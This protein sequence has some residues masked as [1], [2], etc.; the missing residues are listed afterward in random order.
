MALPWSKIESCKLVLHA[1]TA[2][3]KLQLF[4]FEQRERDYQ[5]YQDVPT[6]KYR[7]MCRAGETRVR[8][9]SN[10]SVMSADNM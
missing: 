8:R 6:S 1:H 5:D 4:S 7:V 9:V 3:G 10:A 2:P